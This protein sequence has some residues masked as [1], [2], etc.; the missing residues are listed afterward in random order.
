MVNNNNET[1]IDFKNVDLV[2]FKFYIK[3]LLADSV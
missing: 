2:K 1:N 3:I